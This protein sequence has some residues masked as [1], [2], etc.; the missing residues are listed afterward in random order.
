MAASETWASIERIRRGTDPSVERAAEC[1]P[2]PGVYEGPLKA[3]NYARPPRWGNRLGARL[4]LDAEF[5][6]LGARSARGPDPNAV[7]LRGGIGLRA[8]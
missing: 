2:S 1:L 8:R 4:K 5:P 3:R 7:P 6:L